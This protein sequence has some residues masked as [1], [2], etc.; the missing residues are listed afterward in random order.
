MLARAAALA[1]ALL[2]ASGAAAQLVVAPTPAPAAAPVANALDGFPFGD[3]R[4]SARRQIL[5]SH[6]I[7]PDGP[8][9]RRFLEEGL[10]ASVLSRPLPQVPEFKGDVV[11]AAI[12]EIG[13]RQDLESGPLLRQLIAR[14]AVP[15]ARATLQIDL[16]RVPVDAIAETRDRYVRLFSLD[17]MIAAGLANDTEA[18]PA[19]LRLVQS[20]TGSRF[21]TQ[22][23]IALAL[24]GRPEGIAPVV[25]LA[26]K[27][28]SGES[29][30]AFETLFVITGRNYGV[31]MESS[32]AKRRAKMEELL[33]WQRFEGA[34]FVPDRKSV[35]R[36]RLAPL[37]APPQPDPASL[38]GALRKSVDASDQR[39]R[40]AARVRLGDMVR[41]NGTEELRAVAEDPME[42][43]D[44]RGEALRWLAASEPKAARK[45]LKRLRKA[46]EPE[47]AEMARTL[48]E[49]ND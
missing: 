32:M 1:A 7:N 29:I 28:D 8:S 31:G 24:L 18:A 27:V 37:P 44:I 42:D 6:G 33:E 38:R 12:E 40:I 21:T 39:A 22:G 9:L 23:A 30:A 36:R 48:L 15:G 25:A 34:S 43:T 11:L 19:I 10:P 16:E 35:L 46:E 26:E 17:A 2:L 41:A 4:A 45:T 5:L 3:A 20:E 49:K 14:E 47:L 13:I